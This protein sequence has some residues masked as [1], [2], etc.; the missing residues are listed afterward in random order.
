MIVLGISAFYHDAA[1]CLL[2]DGELVAAAQEERFTRRKGEARL[3]VAAFRYCLNEAGCGVQDLDLVAFYE[4]PDLK[5]ERQRWMLRAYP[6]PSSPPRLAA[7]DAVEREI[8]QR[9]G[10]EAPLRTYRHHRSHAASAYYFSGFDDAA[11]LTVDGVGEWA[12][13]ALWRGRGAALEPLL[14]VAFPHSLG[15]LYSAVTAFLGFAANGGESKVMGLAS[16]GQPIYAR[17]LAER[18][19]WVDDGRF[20]LD[21]TLFRGFQGLGDLVPGLS[22]LFHGPPRAPGD[23]LTRRH[24]DIAASLQ[25]VLEESL[26]RLAAEARRRVDSSNLC[27]AGGVA[28]NGVGNG[29]LRRSGLFDQLFV[30]PAPGDSGACLGAAVLATLGERSTPTQALTHSSFGPSFSAGEV[31]T[32]LER[33]AIPST[34]YRE[35]PAA[36]YATLAERLARG[37]VVGWFQ[38][39]MEMGPRA[40][41]SRSLLASPLDPAVRDRLNRQIKGREDWRPFGPC[42]LASRVSDYLELEAPSPF[43]METCRVRDE[44]EWPAVT[45][46]DGST[47]PQTVDPT[48]HPRLAALLRAFEARTNCPALLNT[49]FNRA[50]EPIVCSPLD[51]LRTFALAGFDTLVLGDHL[52]DA[53]DL[54]PHLISRLRARD[55]LALPRA[56]EPPLNRQ[57]YRLV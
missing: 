48:V 14:E 3:P 1:C 19:Q 12:T 17:E 4:S 18:I 41:G 45:H 35:D 9:L 8:R 28:L 55:P 27:F 37:Q 11:I 44:T 25:M 7:P 22:A 30:P 32:F 39:R 43:M 53:S 57:L 13:T 31:A 47:R 46:V 16:Y 26:L 20:E 23:S 24:R 15:L 56:D 10:I 38:G 36:L 52:V 21:Q 40:L 54:P 29:R 33:A 2:R 49:S 6:P 42:I 51:A 5:L 50:G 34:D